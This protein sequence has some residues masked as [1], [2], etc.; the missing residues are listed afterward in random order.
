MHCSAAPAEY[1]A[2]QQIEESSRETPFAPMSFE[3][4]E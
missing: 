1:I 2:S 4:G 3:S